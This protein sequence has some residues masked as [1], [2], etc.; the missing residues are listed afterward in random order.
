MPLAGAP[1][2]LLDHT[3]DDRP[4]IPGERTGAIRVAEQP[5]AHVIAW[6]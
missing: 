5:R 2:W 1:G 3:G 6:E 4:T